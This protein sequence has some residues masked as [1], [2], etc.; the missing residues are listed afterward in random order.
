M[1]AEGYAALEAHLKHCREDERPRI[2][3]QIAEARGADDVSENVEYH[4]AT[5]LQSLNEARIAEL[6]DKLARAEVIDTS[7]LSGKTITF[8]ATVTLSR[9]GNGK[10]IRV[11]RVRGG[12]QEE[13]NL[14]RLAARP[15]AYREEDKVPRL[16]SQ[17]RGARRITKSSQSNGRSA[18]D[19]WHRARS[20]FPLCIPD[21]R[22][23]AGLRATNP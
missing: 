20:L 1:T 10:E 12:R 11:E 7:K 22:D 18:L 23:C 17:R 15:G 2:I 13:K 8:G 4:A 5:E 9:R 21:S 19:R 16:K 14:V 3:E 6:E